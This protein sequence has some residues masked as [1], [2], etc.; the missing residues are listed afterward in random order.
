MSRKPHRIKVSPCDNLLRQLVAEELIREK[1][2][3]CKLATRTNNINF[4]GYIKMNNQ[5]MNLGLGLT[6]MDGKAVVSSRD[7][8]RVFEKRHD[9]VLRDIKNI[10]D[11]D[12]EWDLLNFEEMSY[13]DSYGRNQTEYAITRDGFTLLVMGYTGEKAMGFKKAYIAA[14]NEMERK[15][16]PRNYKQALLALVAAEEAREALEAQNEVLQLTAAKYEGQTDTVGL[17]KAGDIA[18]EI[19]TTA[20]TLNRFLRDCR[21][22]YK[23]NGSQ[24]WRLYADYIGDNLALPKIVTLDNGYEMPI[25]LWTPKGRDFIYDLAERE[26]PTWY[27]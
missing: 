2:L 9:N 23:P 16:T 6:E 1:T 3:E 24:T 7:I 27:A 15:L 8:S 4:G 10:I 22:Q 21:V 14:F 26:M 20:V 11:S 12:A 13:S 25:L 17:Y 18:E 5:L 19:G